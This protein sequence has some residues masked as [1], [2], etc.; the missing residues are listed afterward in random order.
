VLSG[1]SATGKDAIGELLTAWGLP[2]HLTVNA[3]TRPP[4][5]GETDGA[6]YHFVSEAEFD[7]LEAA[8]GLIESALVYGQ[9]KGVLRSEVVDP[10]AAGQDVIARVDVQGAATLRRLF[11]DETVL[12]FVAPPSL[13][14]AQRRLESRHTESEA[15]QRLR[16]ETA[17][18]E[19]DAA[20]EFDHV[21]VNETGQ[22]E[23][24][25]RRIV[26]IIA[27]EKGRRAVAGD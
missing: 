9:R 10:L 5:P 17:E 19:M 7:R 11:P 4:R 27:A 24:T 15:E 26:E 13:A 25:A 22:L 18:T 20:R 8:G 16:L 1:P 23:Q 3:T 12:I 2:A 14:E 6:D 21:V